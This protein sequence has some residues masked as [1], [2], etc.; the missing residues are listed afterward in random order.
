MKRKVAVFTGTRA[1][2]GLLYWLMKDIQASQVLELQVI[3]SGMHLSPEFGETWKVIDS[4]G[5]GIDAK[6]EMLLS[7]DSDVGVVKS[8]G[9]GILGFADAL[10]R[11]RPDVL[12][13]LGDRFEALAIVQSAL[14]M[15][16]PVA[17]LHGGEITEGAYDD[18]IRHAI[19]KMSYLHFVAADAYRQ[20]VIQ[21]GESPERVFNVGAVGLDHLLRSER[22]SRAELSESLDFVLDSPFLLVTY[23]PVTLAEEDPVASFEALLCALDRFPEYKVIITY[24][25]ADNGGRAIIPLLEAYAQQTPERVK[26]IPSLGFKR[27][28]SAVALADAV[29]GN[30]SSGI[31]EVPAFAVPTVNI[32]ARQD[33]RL[34]A[35]SILH[36][37]AQADAIE[38]TLREALSE[39]F[40]EVC[41][42]A[43]N[44]YGAGNAS[45]SI[46]SVL[47]RFDMNPN[48]S[49]Q[50]LV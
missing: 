15:K 40:A 25:N 18:A 5:F 46:A 42:R 24:P 47:E 9:L 26:A 33:G 7:S 48:K 14:V 3:V 31:I 35:E 10:D 17:H 45:H 27:Y 21:M 29:V 34:A 36:C 43:V 19:T 37:K 4:D 8:M 23:H 32:G 13:V 16:I 2:Y 50:D 6:V 44:P 22:M 12:V 39:E 30:S 28:L 20:R 49:F 1:E 41:K 38:G 11:L